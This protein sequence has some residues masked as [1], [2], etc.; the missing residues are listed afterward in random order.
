MLATVVL[1]GLAT[2]VLTG[3]LSGTR[4][5]F[6]GRTLR[7][8]LQDLDARARLAARTS[9]AMLLSVTERGRLVRLIERD[10]GRM[11]RRLELGDDRQLRLFAPGST[12]TLDFDATGRSPDYRVVLREGRERFAWRVSGETGW[13]SEEER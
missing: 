4:G 1:I 3:K 5:A 8:E 11:I 13:I 6:A 10:S 12:D 2:T 9:G 7:G